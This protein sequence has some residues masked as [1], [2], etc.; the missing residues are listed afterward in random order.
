MQINEENYRESD[1]RKILIIKM[2]MD[3]IVIKYYGEYRLVVFYTLLVGK[4][5]VNIRS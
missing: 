2:E 1:I 3:I 5:Q 4:K